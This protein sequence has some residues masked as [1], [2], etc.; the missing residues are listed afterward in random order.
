MV[1]TMNFAEMDGYQFEVFICNLFRKLGFEVEATNYSNDGGIDL[2]ATFQKP[3]F[4]GKYIIQCKN[5]EGHV[6]QPEVRDLYG[7]VMDQRANKGILITPSDYTEQ[8][9]DFAKGKNIELINGSILK[10][11]VNEE[12]CINTHS[13]DF[14]YEYRN[15]RYNYLKNNIDEEPN[16]IQNYIDLI[17]YL[18]GFIKEQTCSILILNEYV[19]IVEKLINRCFRKTSKSIDKE[20]AL[21]LQVE[22]YICMGELAKATEI[23]IR[24]NKFFIPNFCSQ[25]QL[26]HQFHGGQGYGYNYLYAWNLYAAYKQI[27]YEKGCELILSKF[28]RRSENGRPLLSSTNVDRPFVGQEVYGKLFVYPL[29]R[30][31]SFGKSVKHLNTNG[32]YIKDMIEPKYFFESFYKRDN[33]D[34]IKEIEK[35]FK[36]NGII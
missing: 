16:E 10:S 24:N 14:D 33:H 12:E 13:N 17:E 1:K 7:V 25:Y 27:G 18:R 21:L 15:D 5:W 20:M 31:C 35:V 19:E 30:M 4:C 32:Y 26:S 23:L 34:L 29:V 22:A 11:L 8:A 28:S 9:Y 6:G 36:L 3:I 2:I